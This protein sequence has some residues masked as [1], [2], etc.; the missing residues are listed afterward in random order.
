MTW[1][2]PSAAARDLRGR[3]AAPLSY[4][5]FARRGR[6]A[7]PATRPRGALSAPDLSPY[8]AARPRDGARRPAE[9]EPV[10]EQ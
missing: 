8:T 7:S 9:S 5:P 1:G 3:P 6:P 4:Y 10:R 2:G